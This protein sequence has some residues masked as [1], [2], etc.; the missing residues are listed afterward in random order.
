M[1]GSSIRHSHLNLQVFSFNVRG[2][3]NTVK[4]KM[5]FNF[6]K[7]KSKRAIFLLQ[8]THSCLETEKDWLD[9]WG[10]DIYFSHGSSNSAGVATLV[11]PGLD[12]TCIDEKTNDQGRSLYITIKLEDENEELLLVNVYAPTRDKLDCQLQ[13]L[14]RVKQY[15]ASLDYIHL[16]VGG[17]FNTVFDPDMDKEGGDTVN[18]INKYT[19]ELLSFMEANE[20][21][22]VIRIMYPDRKLFTRVQR[23]PRVFSRIDHWLLSEHTC[24][25]ISSASVQPSIK[26]DHSVIELSLGKNNT[27]G[28]GYWKFNANLLHDTDYVKKTKNLIEQLKSETSYLEDK[29]LRWDYIKCAIRGLTLSYSFNKNKKKKEYR[30]NLYKEYERLFNLYQQSGDD[31]DILLE[32]ETVKNEVEA[33]EREHINGAIIRSKAKWTEAG[34][35]NTKYFLNLEKRNAI[36]KNI[37]KLTDG[38]NTVIEDTGAILKAC[39]HFYKTLYQETSSDTSREL[40]SHL[41]QTFFPE[42]HCVLSDEER[43]L[44]DGLITM[45]ECERSIKNMKNGKSPGSD[46]F[47]AEFYKFFWTDIKHLVLESI[48]FA[49]RKG[50]LSIDQKRGIITLIPKKGKNRLLLKNW[51]PISLLN[52]DY[53]ILTKCLSFRIQKVLP[54]IINSDQTGY[55]KGRY[56]GENIRTISDLIDFTSLRNMPGVILLID[57][58]KAFDTIRWSF[59]FKSLKYFNFSDSFIHWIKTIY[60]STESA[61]INNGHVSNKFSLSRGIR[62]GCPISPYLF[63]IAA[64]IMAISI[65]NNTKI[66]GITVGETEI[67]LSQLADDT[68]V[69]VSDVDSVKNTLHCLQDF[70]MLSGLKLNIEKTVAMGI[71]SLQGLRPE[72]TLGLSWTDGPITTLG[73]TISSDP[74]IVHDLCFTPCIRNAVNVLNIWKQ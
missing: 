66:T 56:I 1:T 33:L 51:R 45:E 25:Y 7:Q 39:E 20:L 22:D 38:N 13:F 50:E 49:Y 44:C 62:Q 23:K 9:D 15:V 72:D 24:N 27:R 68:T 70:Y 55:I 10:G 34:E 52:T 4:R 65:R 42:E 5:V 21:Q 16:L 28:M 32:Y 30:C 11:S 47:T 43:T 59:L 36:N 74:D 41:L 37:V 71:G 26:S 69:F 29:G 64:E 67:K 57:F 48:N 18:C 46:G 61:V 12:I 58:E 6:L 8:E 19:D 35:K 63:I 53:K 60:N 40:D 54:S 17:D 31:E 14:D 3:A 73:V 2:L